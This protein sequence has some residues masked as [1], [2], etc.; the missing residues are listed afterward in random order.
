MTPLEGRSWKT[1]YN[2]FTHLDRTP[3]KTASWSVWATPY[4]QLHH[5]KLNFRSFA[6]V[7]RITGVPEYSPRPLLSS[8]EV[9]LLYHTKQADSSSPS[10][11]SR[12]SMS[13]SPEKTERRLPLLCVYSL[14][15][16]FLFMGILI[17]IKARERKTSHFQPGY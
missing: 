11:Q 17:K 9:I 8:S 12:N 10:A 7:L 15:L 4:P 5:R 13:T 14:S 16:K 1:V 2:R 6:G 3:K